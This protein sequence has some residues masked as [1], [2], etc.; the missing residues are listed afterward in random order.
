[1]SDNETI[2][3]AIVN[4]FPV[5][6]EGLARLLETDRRLE[7]IEVD[8]NIGPSQ[9][10]DVV[11]Y[12]TFGAQERVVDDVREL[13]GSGRGTNV[14]VYSWNVDHARIEEARA[15]GV[16]GYLSKALDAVSLADAIVRVHGGDVV[17]EPVPTRGEPLRMPDWPGRE[18]GLSP[19]EAEVLSLIAQGATND[20]IARRCF[21]SI[22]SVKTYIRSAYR[23]IDVERRSQAVRWAVEHGMLPQTTRQSGAEATSKADRS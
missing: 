19:R 5:V 11:L 4:D 20:E 7:V 22:N 12:D 15:C 2:T 18:V 9:P 10:V 3:V 14:V 16:R 13:I 1:M 6:V 17:I 23:K 8:T 21:L